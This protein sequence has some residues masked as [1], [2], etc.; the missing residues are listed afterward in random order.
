MT[1][2]SIG[3]AVLQRDGRRHDFVVCEAGGVVTPDELE[4]IEYEP[5]IFPGLVYRSKVGGVA[6]IF[7]SGAMIVADAVSIPQAQ[8]VSDEVWHLVDRAGAGMRTRSPLLADPTRAAALWPGLTANGASRCRPS[9]VNAARM[10]GVTAG[11]HRTEPASRSNTNRRG[12]GWVNRRGLDLPLQRV[13][14]RGNRIM[15]I[16]ISSNGSLS[17]KVQSLNPDLATFR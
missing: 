13:G 17:F 10:A 6:R 12:W 1:E 7:T 8:A 11:F 14:G 15:A 9:R 3:E 4:R 16:P 5:E 2:Q